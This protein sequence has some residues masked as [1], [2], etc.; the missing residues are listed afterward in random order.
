MGGRECSRRKYFAESA[1]GGHKED[2]APNQQEH[3]CQ[4]TSDLKPGIP[5]IPPARAAPEPPVFARIFLFYPPLRSPVLVTGLNKLD[6]DFVVIYCRFFSSWTAVSNS[7]R[8]AP[9]STARS[10]SSWA[11]LSRFRAI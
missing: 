6:E 9:S 3:R 7:T 11:S 10:M 5:K 2:Q 4:S 8:S 1:S